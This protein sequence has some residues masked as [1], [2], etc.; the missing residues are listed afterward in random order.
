MQRY[1]QYNSYKESGLVWLGE[2]PSH[3]EGSTINALTKVVSRKNKPNE[4]LLSVYRDYGVILKSSRDDNYN[5]PGQDLSAYKY[6]KPTNLVLNKMKTW[7]GS[8]GVSELQGIVSPAYITCELDISNVFPKYLH[9]LLRCHNY[10]YEY[11]RL[12]Y[13]VRTNQWD[14]RYDDFKKTP[15][16]LPSKQE[17]RAIAI[18]L[19]YKTA[20]I[21]RFITNEEKLITL[22]NEQKAAIINHAVTK[23][24]NPNVPMKPSEVEGIRE[25]PKGWRLI[26]LKYVSQI[27]NSGVWGE[28]QGMLDI[29]TPVST[30]AHL[31]RDGN[32]LIEQMPIRSFSKAD[33][34]YYSGKNGDIIIVKSSGSATNIIT[35]K[36][37]FIDDFSEGIIFSNFLMRVKLNLPPSFRQ[38]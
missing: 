24:L 23:G 20:E 13:G 17:Q 22:L 31:T 7:Q 10:I 35:G 25:I 32:W 18:F 3:W 37:G 36:A 21:D 28:E 33:Y 2:T 8:L 12:S 11:N 1:K 30:T 9:Y 6:V 38:Q 16:F 5:R 34:E 29:D 19:D 4:P 15:V 14:M 27:D 26:K